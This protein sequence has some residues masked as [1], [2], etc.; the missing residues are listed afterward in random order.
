MGAQ[1]QAIVDFGA[2]PGT[3]RATFAVTGQ[4]TI[5]GSSLCEA[6]L[7][8]TAPATTD[9]APDEHIVESTNMAVTCS[10]I[11]ASTGFTINLQAGGKFRLYGKWNVAWVWN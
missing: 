9:H 6:W 10:T 4:G 1:G 8:P 7:D 5:L 3:D 11:V 2:F